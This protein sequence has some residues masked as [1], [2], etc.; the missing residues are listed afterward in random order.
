MDLK[1][2]KNYMRIDDDLTDDDALIQSLADAAQ[3]YI[4][5]QTGKQYNSDKLWNVC[6]CLLVA[7]WYDNRQLN[8][9]KP[10]SLAEFPHSVTA[11]INHI[12]LSAAYPVAVKS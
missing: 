2:I 6:I 7:H 5:N 9:S 4:Q 1:K 12:A 8:P 3:Q 11:L 10:G